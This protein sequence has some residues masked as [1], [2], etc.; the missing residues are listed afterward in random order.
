MQLN[1]TSSIH[2]FV[3]KD[4]YKPTFHATQNP[5]RNHESLIHHT[6]K[7]N[8]EYILKQKVGASG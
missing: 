1:N 6:D 3:T 8:I 7:K 5:I 2:N 4:W